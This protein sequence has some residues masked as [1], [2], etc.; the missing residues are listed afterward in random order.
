MISVMKR[1]YMHTLSTRV[2]FRLYTSVDTGEDGVEVMS[3][4][5]VVLVKKA[6][7]FFVHY[8]KAVKGMRQGLEGHRVVV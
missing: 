2:H 5:Y 6:I 1:N 8:V 3:A 4:I 7:L